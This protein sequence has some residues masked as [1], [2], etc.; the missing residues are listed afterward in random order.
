MARAIRAIEFLSRHVENTKSLDIG[1][2][3]KSVI[4]AIKSFMKKYKELAKLY[5]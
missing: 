5:A 4:F 2:T 3:K 1:S